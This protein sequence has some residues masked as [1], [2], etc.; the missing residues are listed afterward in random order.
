MKPFLSLSFKMF[1]NLPDS[2]EPLVFSISFQKAK[3]SPIKVFFNAG[4]SQ[5]SGFL[6][7]VDNCE[8]NSKFSSLVAFWRKKIIATSAF[9]T[10]FCGDISGLQKY[11]QN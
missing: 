11:F 5:M 2:T 10:P 8:Y 4:S 6:K 3:S 9:Q 1:I 7:T